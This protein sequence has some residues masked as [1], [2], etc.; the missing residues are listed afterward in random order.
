M[1]SASARPAGDQRALSYAGRT[2]DEDESALAA[3]CRRQAIVDDVELP[4]TL[5]QC[6]HRSK[7]RGDR[8]GVMWPKSGT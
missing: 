1:R 4:A 3:L 6:D 8:S 5:E 2:L 7:R